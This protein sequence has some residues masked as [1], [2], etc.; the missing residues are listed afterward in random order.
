M[1]AVSADQIGAG[2][3]WLSRWWWVLPAVLAG[4]TAVLFMVVLPPDRHVEA[5]YDVPV[6]VSPVVFAVFAIAGFPRL[7]RLGLALVVTTIIVFMGL[8]DTGYI[9]RIMAYGAAEDQE[10]AFPA[11]YQFQLFVSAFVVL[12]VLFAYRLGGAATFRT[13]KAGLAGVLVMLS[14]LNDL[15]AWALDSWPGGRPETLFWASHIEV[16]LGRPPTPLMALAFCLVH[17]AVAAAILAL[18]LQQWFDRLRVSAAR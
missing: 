11:L 17:L 6:K 13:L 16:F 18:P 8:V 14:G 2:P 1:T 4:V 9:I 15:T 3:S 5:W 12:A 7:P 10:A